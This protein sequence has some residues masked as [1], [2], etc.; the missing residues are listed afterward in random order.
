M[1]TLS[2]LIAG[3][4]E[5]DCKVPTMP[6]HQVV[7]RLFG[8]LLCQN[9]RSALDFQFQN[10]SALTRDTFLLNGSGLRL[11]VQGKVQKKHILQI[12]TPELIIKNSLC[13]SL[14]V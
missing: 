6:I 1:Q 10:L 2:S 4:L 7:G 12:A 3:Y 9:F 5:T 11:L 13:V 14:V 8:I